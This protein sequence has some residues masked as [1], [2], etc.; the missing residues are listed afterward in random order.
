MV[1]QPRIT[2][3]RPPLL[4]TE[5]LLG[6]NGCGKRFGAAASVCARTC[7]R[8]VRGAD[9]Y[10]TCARS[11]GPCAHML[12]C[13]HGIGVRCV[14]ACRNALLVPKNHFFRVTVHGGVF[15]GR[16]WGGSAEH[17]TVLVLVLV[18]LLVLV[19]VLIYIYLCCIML[20]I[21]LLKYVFEILLRLN[22]LR[23]LFTCS[24]V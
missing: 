11:L 17:N 24:G 13:A 4:P 19:I 23:R 18:L 5:Q 3:S 7:A 9:M 20:L 1:A 6:K 2:R 22:W 15:F 21:Y 8:R 16:R 14:P 10:R 12:A